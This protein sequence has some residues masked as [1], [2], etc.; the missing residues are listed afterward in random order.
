MRIVQIN[1]VP[2]GSTGRIM[3]QLADALEKRGHKVLCTSGFTWRKSSRADFFVTSNIFEK[4]AHTYLARLTGRTGGFSYMAT[5]RLLKRLDDFA[6]E[7]IHLHNLH[8]WFVNIPMLF[9][10]IRKKDIPVVWTLHDCWAFTGHCPHFDA[11]NCEK[12]KTEC[13]CCPQYRSYPATFFDRSRKMY[14]LKR[15]WTEGISRMTIVPPSNWLGGL[16]RQSF[17]ADYN[18]QVIHNGINLE[19]FTPESSTAL[20]D[21]FK[22]GKHIVLGAAYKWDHRKGLDVFLELSKRLDDAYRIVLVGTDDETDRE[23]PDNIVSV[24]RTQSQ[25]EMAALYSAADVFVNP[26]RE[27]NFPTVN[28][29]ALACGTPVITFDTGGSPEIPDESCGVVVP[30]DDV[31]ALEREI[32]RVCKEKP[33]TAQQC[34][35]RAK[36]FDE[37]NCIREYLELYGSMV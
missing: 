23:L 16:V 27:D 8:G 14:H 30:K 3:F 21:T 17:L 12:W 35:E 32:R 9:D 7:L 28:M 29:E 5:K 22:S 15:K 26:T 24:H 33:F 31:D 34:L 4:T 25:R 11:V 19:I 1:A 2:Y 10:Y 36:V 20:T 18:I 37:S 13:S 6:P